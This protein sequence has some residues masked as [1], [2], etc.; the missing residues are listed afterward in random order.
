MPASSHGPFTTDKCGHIVK[1][2]PALLIGIRRHILSDKR[3]VD[4]KCCYLT[5]DLDTECRMKFFHIFL[6]MF[7]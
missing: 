6:D 1:K 3:Q 7:L 2:M 5:V 4:E